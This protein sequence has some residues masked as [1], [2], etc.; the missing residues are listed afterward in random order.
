M[1]ELLQLIIIINEM[2]N[3]HYGINEL[4]ELFYKYLYEN[5]CMKIFLKKITQL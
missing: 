2:M 5:I 1:I 4:N 3:S